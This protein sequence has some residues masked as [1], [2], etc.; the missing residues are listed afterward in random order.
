MKWVAWTMLACLAGTTQAQT[1]AS[2]KKNLPIQQEQK[3]K[4]AVKP[5]TVKAPVIRF[6][7]EM[8]EGGKISPAYAGFPVSDVIEAI[9]NLQVARKGEFE[10]TDDFKARRIAAISKKFLGG[11]S[12]DD[13][14]AFVVPVP[15]FD[16]Y[17]NGLRYEFDADTGTIKLYVLPRSSEYLALNGIGDPNYPTNRREFK[18]L[19]E[20]I[21]SSKT[22]SKSTYPGSNAYGATVMVQKTDLSAVGI[23]ANR[24]PFLK[25]KRDISY[26]NPA[27]SAQF[28]LENS[29]AASEVPAMKALIVMKLSAPYIIYNF[30]RKEPKRDSPTD[31]SMQE[32]YLYGDVLGIVFYSGKTGEIFARLPENFG[33]AEPSNEMKTEASPASQ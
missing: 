21:L 31:I 26:S 29:R 7:M 18:G 16:K 9:Q 4:D 22:E 27:V 2:T 20:L 1:E 8:L 14:F 25:F 28:K 13:I 12:V 32:K 15:K 11:A 30:T 5:S 33:K 19:D 23:A 3:K 6:S 24:I 10:T 17:S